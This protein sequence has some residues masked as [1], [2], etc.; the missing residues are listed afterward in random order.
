MCLW[1]RWYQWYLLLPSPRIQVGGV[2]CVCRCRAV[3][4]DPLDSVAAG[5]STARLHR[6][7]KDQKLS[8]FLCVFDSFHWVFF[9]CILD[10]FLSLLT[11]L[12]RVRTSY[13]TWSFVQT[14]EDGAPT[15]CH[16]LR[17][18]E[19]GS[20]DTVQQLR[21]KLVGSGSTPVVYSDWELNVS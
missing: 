18:R 2:L 6:R 4:S 16:Q 20:V 17:G 21:A 19:P 3:S 14:R 13:A 9:F 10:V 7:W 11:T 15:P 1:R 12:G 5:V 8:S